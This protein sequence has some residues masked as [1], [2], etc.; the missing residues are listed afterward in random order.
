MSD[1]PVVRHGYF[2]AAHDRAYGD[3]EFLGDL[4]DLF[5]RHW[6]LRNYN[7]DLRHHYSDGISRFEREDGTITT[8]IVFRSFFKA[9]E[10]FV[11]DLTDE[12]INNLRSNIHPIG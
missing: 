9:K 6:T 2:A 3:V 8:R 10:S 7:G 12:D 1:S 4:P 5:R 11:T